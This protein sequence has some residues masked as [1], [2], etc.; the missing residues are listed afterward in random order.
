[1]GPA[2]PGRPNPWA[3][4][5]VSRG[6]TT[7]LWVFFLEWLLRQTSKRGR[8]LAA[9]PAGRE[10]VKC[11]NYDDGDK[12]SSGSPPSD[13]C[14]SLQDSSPSSG[15]RSRAPGTAL[16]STLWTWGEVFGSGGCGESRAHLGQGRVRAPPGESS[17]PGGG[18]KAAWVGDPSTSPSPHLGPGLVASA[19]QAVAAPAALQPCSPAAPQPQSPLG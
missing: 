12:V 8:Q 11:C 2:H 1:M 15:V 4:L 5:Q 14:A 18:R 13:L 10:T 19:S 17:A 9:A 6:L 16:Q 7:P 3:G